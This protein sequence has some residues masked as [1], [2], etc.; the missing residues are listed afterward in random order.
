[1]L[2]RGRR[3]VLDEPYGDEGIAPALLAAEDPLIAFVAFG[4][5]NGPDGSRTEFVVGWGGIYY[6]SSRMGL[7]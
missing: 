6:L 3:P 4:G 7:P 2:G 5:S 1:M